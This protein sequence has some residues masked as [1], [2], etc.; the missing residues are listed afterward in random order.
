MTHITKVQQKISTPHGTLD[1]EVMVSQTVGT[2]IKIF[3]KTRVASKDRRKLLKYYAMCVEKN[4]QL[5]KYGKY[6]RIE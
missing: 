1:A 4:K 6:G 2:I 5:N 3:T